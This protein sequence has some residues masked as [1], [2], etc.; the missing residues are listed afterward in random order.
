MRY[1][2]IKMSVDEPTDDSEPAA[3]ADR[4]PGISTIRKK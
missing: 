2:M 3:R 1:D 4:Y